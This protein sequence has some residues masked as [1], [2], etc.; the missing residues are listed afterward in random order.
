MP[1]V[2]VDLSVLGSLRNIPDTVTTDSQGLAQVFY[3]AG[4]TPGV[5]HIV[6][7]AG[8]FSSG[9]A[10]CKRLSTR[11]LSSILPTGGNERHRAWVAAWNSMV[12]QTRVERGEP[13][14]PQRLPQRTHS[15]GHTSGLRSTSNRG[16]R[17]NG[18][19]ENRCEKCRR[20][21]RSRSNLDVMASQGTVAPVQDNGDGT[22]TAAL[23]LGQS[24]RRRHQ[25]CREHR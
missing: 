22:Y 13:R 7:K 5:V 8:D 24:A 10:C 3:T 23:T 25:D 12:A 17:R 15:S 14:P 21:G 9:T 20:A 16:A 2:N 6:A 19:S 18:F 4:R 11:L 1:G